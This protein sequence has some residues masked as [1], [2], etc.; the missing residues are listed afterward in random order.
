MYRLLCIIP[1][2]SA[3]ITYLIIGIEEWWP[4]YVA[5]TIIGEVVIIWAMY[6]IRRDVE[7]LSGYATAVYH[8]EAW[9]ERVV[10]HE[11]YTDSK[12]NTHTRTVVN[13][14][15]HPD[16]WFCILN[17]GC[18]I[19]IEAES[20]YQICNKWETEE[21][22]IDPPHSNCVAGGGGQM[23]YFDEI[24]EH[25][26]TATYEGLYVNYVRDSNSIFRHAELS[27][28]EAT[29]LALIDYPEISDTTL[30][31]DA[32]LMSPQLK[33]VEITPTMQHAI[34]RINAYYGAEAQIHIFVL[35]FDAA[36]GIATAMK[37]RQYW[38]GGNKNE[39]VV[40]LGIEPSP[41]EGEPHEVAWC[42]VFSWCDAPRLDNATESWF[43]EHR[44]L[45]IDSY[46]KW[47]RL[48]I[49]LWQRKS[50]SD[51]KYMGKQLSPR[52]TLMMASLALLVSALMVAIIVA[53]TT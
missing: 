26:V 28:N 42:K 6:R 29:Q 1:A 39:L 4:L 24:Y 32:I 35:L 11:T 12:G 31:V 52:R 27:S 10:R 47:L 18:N 50:F 23:K 36:Q 15:E 17:T 22:W 13:Y 40:C 34:Q 8:H 49:N 25:M 37:Q 48:N 43:L 21:E 3:A 5:A 7:Y 33:G 44:K 45:D 51:F 20:Y 9:T 41:S 19:D 53:V 14:V 46:A 38:H 2:V 30:D 16:E